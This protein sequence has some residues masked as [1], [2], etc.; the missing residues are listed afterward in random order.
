MK[1]EDVKTVADARKI[2]NERKLAHVKVGVFDIDGIL[3]GKYMSREKFFNSLD[4]GFGFCDVVLGWDSS[5]QLYDNT[6]FTGWHTGYPDAQ[7]RVLPDTC[8]DIPFEPG[9]LFFLAEFTEEAKAPCPRGVL[10]RVLDKAH[11]MGF[12]V[13]AGFEY[14]Y[15][16]FDETPDSVRAKH[17]RDLKPMAP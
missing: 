11:K 6:E 10:R 4:K 17:Y 8:R 13:C 9:M 7:V 16:V 14:E 1:P 5:D 2:V 3:R 12:E 15:F